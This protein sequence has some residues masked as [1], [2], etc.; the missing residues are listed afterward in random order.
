MSVPE[1]DRLAEELRKDRRSDE[2]SFYPSAPLPS[3]S[4]FLRPR[5]D[6]ASFCVSLQDCQP[7]SD[8]FRPAVHLI[9]EVQCLSFLLRQ[10]K[11]VPCPP[12][13]WSAQPAASS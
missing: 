8:L 10:Q 6:R 12:N 3:T 13:P 5:Y 4:C 7:E 2:S 1:V 9:G 11:C